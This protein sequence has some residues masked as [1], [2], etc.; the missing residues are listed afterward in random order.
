MDA[1]EYA[2]TGNL[3]YLQVDNY[4]LFEHETL[5]K[6]P[7]HGSFSGQFGFS[8]LISRHVL[9]TAI[10]NSSGSAHNYYAATVNS[11]SVEEAMF[12]R[13][14]A[15]VTDA[16]WGEASL[17]LTRATHDIASLI[18]GA[19]NAEHIE[20]VTL[21]SALALK[22]RPIET[23]LLYVRRA[24]AERPGGLNAVQ[25]SGVPSSYLT[26]NVINYEVGSKYQTH[27][28]HFRF[29]AATFLNDWNNVQSTILTEDGLTFIANIGQGR[30]IGAEADTRWQSD[31]GLFFSAN[32]LWQ[33]ARLLHSSD[34]AIVTPHFLPAVPD[35]MS[36]AA[37]G[38]I[39]TASD[40]ARF[41]IESRI[42]YLGRSYLSVQSQLSRPYG[43]YA[44]IGLSAAYKRG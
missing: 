29:N 30:I 24:D 12:G 4:H 33:Q 21:N 9:T 31:N 38:Y 39:Y 11:R 19:T 6:S 2:A 34:P 3:A 7:A 40:D 13:A 41:T 23:L 5:V 1:T 16:I 27:G 8:T 10:N 42:K 25:R 26:D 28:K 37:M 14:E 22:W 43:R 17:R 18:N 35:F 36:N 20:G 15:H 44:I 32:V